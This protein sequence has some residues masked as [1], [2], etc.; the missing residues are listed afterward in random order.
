ML[1]ASSSLGSEALVQSRSTW[2]L[3]Y[4]APPKSADMHTLLPDWPSSAR[5]CSWTG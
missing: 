2:L 4:Y 3:Y 5:S 1:Y